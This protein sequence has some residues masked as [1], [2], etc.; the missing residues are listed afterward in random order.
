MFEETK[1]RTKTKNTMRIKVCA[2]G[3]LLPVFGIERRRG[4]EEDGGETGSGD[5]ASKNGAI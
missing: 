2:H 3:S 5:L 4:E 1:A